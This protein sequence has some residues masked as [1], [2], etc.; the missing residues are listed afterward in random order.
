MPPIIEPKSE[1]SSTPPELEGAEAAPDL[2]DRLRKLSDRK[3]D[4]ASRVVNAYSE[5][6]EATDKRWG[7]A[8]NRRTFY[9]IRRWFFW[10][11][12]V[13]V[14]LVAAVCS[15]GYLYLI[16]LWL[17]NVI[18]GSTLKDPDQLKGIITNVLW[19]V[20]VILATLFGESV[21][22]DKDD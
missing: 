7:K 5:D 19:T 16:W 11:L 13:L 3:V 2:L 9:K 22:K 1:R 8:E 18:W 10:F 12:F 15:I 20:L 4:S 17:E 14:C 21:F 6:D